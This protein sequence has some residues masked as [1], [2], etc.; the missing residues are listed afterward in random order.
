[1]KD[2]FIAY[3]SLVG[4]NWMFV[5]EHWI[6]ILLLTIA[7]VVILAPVVATIVVP[8]WPRILWNNFTIRFSKN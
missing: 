4:Q 5:K 8:S 2:F 1:M 3:W 7:M 6:G